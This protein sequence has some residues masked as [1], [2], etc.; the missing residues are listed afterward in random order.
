LNWL[1]NKVKQSQ[2]FQN[3]LSVKQPVEST[4]PQVGFSLS[5]ENKSFSKGLRFN[6]P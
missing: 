4:F 1:D 2:A 5:L 6:Q 3:P